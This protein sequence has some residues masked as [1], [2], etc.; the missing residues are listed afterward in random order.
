[1]VSAGVL[2][3]NVTW[4]GKTY[5][6]TLLDCTRHDWAPPRFCDS[7]T[8]DLDA[9]APKGRG[10][11][12]RAGTGAGSDLANFTETRSSVHSKLR[13][14]T[15]KGRSARAAT[16]STAGGPASPT[17]RPE[18]A[19]PKA[20][21][22]TAAPPA[23]APPS[24]A[25]AP[26]LATSP[27]PLTVRKPKPA[28]SGSPPPSPV[29]LECPEPNCCKKYKHINGLK[30][31]QAHAHGSADDEDTKD[32]TSLSETEES[33]AEA[34]S[35]AGTPD[36]SPAD[37]TDPPGKETPSAP[38]QDPLALPEPSP[39][40][41]APPPASP[42]LS[43]STKSVVKPGVLRFGPVPEDFAFASKAVIAPVAPQPLTAATAA[44]QQ[45]PI[46]LPQF[47]VKPAAALMPEEKL[48]DRSK[49]PG[50]K[51]KKKSPEGSP[52]PT[53][54]PAFGSDSGGREDLQSPAYSDI[55]DD[56]APVL[57]SEVAD[58]DKGCQDKKGEA[59][60]GSSPHGI[61]PY[62]GLFNAPFYGQPPY[63]VPSVP[64]ECKPNK[65]PL[66]KVELK[67][68]EKEIKK[69]PGRSEYPQKLLQHPSHFYSYGYVPGYPGGF[70]ESGYPVMM[71]DKGKE[72]KGDKSPGPCEP[73]KHTPSPIQVPNP[74]KV[75]TEPKHSNENH[76]IIK[77]SIE[78]KS[79]MGQFMY[80]RQPGGHPMQDDLRR[81][82]CQRGKQL[83][84]K[85]P[86]LQKI[87][88]V[89]KYLATLFLGGS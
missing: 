11:R 18:Q 21:E 2:V 31:H 61:S 65:E 83:D 72:G 26:V 34:P 47:K 63:L 16:P 87:Y 71:E 52:H 70:M 82:L 49:P 12:G 44:P 17:P 32:G 1:M 88:Y 86:Y 42:P 85:Y 69:E 20:K 64:T 77:E 43:D 89:H 33:N 9:R 62:V 54:E 41:P 14:G 56:A 30:Y 75:K 58:K 76:Q 35:P 6:G 59:G 55:S 23:P 66:E 53:C 22:A 73:P 51:K 57:E 29:L 37:K 4:R 84:T 80:S 45:L 79:Q 68:A 48:K 39:E 78:M 28:V 36:K 15:A 81:Y 8:S 67:P 40:P 50:Y 38:P 74:A 3:V 13:N 7:P 10:K 46:K 19:K 60:D 25:P 27:A 5:V 24:P